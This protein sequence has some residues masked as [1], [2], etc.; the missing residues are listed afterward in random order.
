MRACRTKPYAASSKVS[1]TASPISPSSSRRAPSRRPR[2]EKGRP[3]SIRPVKRVVQSKPTIE[4][5]GVHLRR[6]F[7]FGET[8]ETDPFLLFDDFRNDRPDDYLTNFPW[9]PHR[10][11]ETITYT[12]AGSETHSNTH[13][14][15][16][17]QH[18]KDKQKKTTSRGIMH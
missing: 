3:M 7:G 14:K 9:Q 13:N 2:K 18:T 16:N 12:L 15:H 8:S 1:S 17:T 5:A 10:G 11:I 4:G 6:A